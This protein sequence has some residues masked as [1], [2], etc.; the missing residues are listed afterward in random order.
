MKVT[1]E[2]FAKNYIISKLK[3]DIED[4]KILRGSGV[5]RV[6]L[7]INAN[8]CKNMSKTMLIFT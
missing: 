2:S 3:T 1:V 5:T 6:T 8:N 4:R 7:K